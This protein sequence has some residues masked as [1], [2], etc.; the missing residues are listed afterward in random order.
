MNFNTYSFD[1]DLFKT[2][3]NNGN[4]NIC[5]A[6]NEFLRMHPKLDIK[7]I[8]NVD[9]YNMKINSTC[10]QL[11][12]GIEIPYGRSFKL[13]SYQLEEYVDDNTYIAPSQLIN[14]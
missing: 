9:G 7:L 12:N 1:E 14:I 5:I 4:V 11:Q 13:V 2:T 3:Q 6:T 10:Q 8:C